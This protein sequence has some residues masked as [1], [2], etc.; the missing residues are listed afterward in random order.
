MKERCKDHLHYNE[1]MLFSLLSWN[2]A[3][4]LVYN[5]LCQLKT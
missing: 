2:C 4:P 3:G 5:K 1:L